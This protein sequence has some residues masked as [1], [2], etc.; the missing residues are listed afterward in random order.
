MLGV[1]HHHAADAASYQQSTVDMTGSAQAVELGATADFRYFR[2][3]VPFQGFSLRLDIEPQSDFIAS[4]VS[5][6]REFSAW[7][8][9]LPILSLWNAEMPG[10]HY[11]GQLIH[12]HSLE[13]W[14]TGAVE[15]T[16]HPYWS[17]DVG[18]TYYRHNNLAVRLYAG[19]AQ[20]PF[21]TR[22]EH[23][24]DSPQYIMQSWDTKT[25]SFLVGLEVTLSAGEH[26]LDFLLFLLDEDKRQRAFGDKH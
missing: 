20:I 14:F 15:P 8:L 19:Y 18:L 6:T 3:S 5:E 22:M 21:R 11:P 4:D 7:R 9:D 2:L 26:A 16:R 23:L 1:R 10:I 12:R 24:T 25:G 17:T 13:L